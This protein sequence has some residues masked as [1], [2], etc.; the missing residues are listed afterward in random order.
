MFAQVHRID[1]LEYIGSD[2][3]VDF[4]VDD[5]FFASDM[6]TPMELAGA[7]VHSFLS[8]RLEASRAT[9]EIAAVRG[10]R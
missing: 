5:T 1:A 8:P 9:E 2:A 10:L 7:S 4:D 3:G 6:T